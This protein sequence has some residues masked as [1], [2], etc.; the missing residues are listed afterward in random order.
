MMNF[1]EFCQSKKAEYSLKRND[2]KRKAKRAFWNATYWLKDNYDVLLLVVPAGVFVVRSGVKVTKLI[3]HNIALSQ[4]RKVK[5][6][7]IYDRSLGKYLELKRPLKNNDMKT[8][9]ERKE[10]GEK[11]SSILMDLNLIR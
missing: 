10:N 6:L 7:R 4:E 11:L 1:K 2:F 8:I 3:S 9:L 5:D